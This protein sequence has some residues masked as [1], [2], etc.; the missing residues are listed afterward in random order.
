[1]K[2]ELLKIFLCLQTTFAFETRLAEGQW[3]EEQVNMLKLRIF[4]EGKRRPAVS[5]AE[6]QHLMPLK[7]PILRRADPRPRNSTDCV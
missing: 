1:M 6:G 7:T 5:R 4:R 3:L 2:Q